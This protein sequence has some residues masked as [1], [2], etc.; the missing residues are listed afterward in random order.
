M[1]IPGEYL[2]GW[3][4]GQL[5]GNFGGICDRRNSGRVARERRGENGAI[6]TIVIAP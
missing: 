5:Y 3:K 4:E 1:S 6:T 2:T